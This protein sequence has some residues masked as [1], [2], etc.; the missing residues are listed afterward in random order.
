MELVRL[1]EIKNSLIDFAESVKKMRIAV[2]D[3]EQRLFTDVETFNPK[4]EIQNYIVSKS[5]YHDLEDLVNLYRQKG[6]KMI[7]YLLNQIFIESKTSLIS[8]KL[9]IAFRIQLYSWEACFR[10]SINQNKRK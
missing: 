10:L 1:K 9:Q 6:I 5:R 7:L 2:F 4:Q 3:S 8:F